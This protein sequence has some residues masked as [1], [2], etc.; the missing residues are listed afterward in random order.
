[1]VSSQQNLGSRFN[2]YFTKWIEAEAFHQVRDHEVK[3]F[4]WN[5][6]ICCFGVLKEIV[7]DND[8]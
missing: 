6:V 4:I 3:N 2:N 1:M 8:S 7:I 5:N